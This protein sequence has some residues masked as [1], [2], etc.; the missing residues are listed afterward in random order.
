[1]QSIKKHKLGIYTICY[2]DDNKYIISGSADRCL[3][4]FG[5]K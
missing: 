3:K 1:M 5:C 2:S 4:I